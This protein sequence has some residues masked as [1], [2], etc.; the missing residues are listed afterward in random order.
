VC[1]GVCLG[2]RVIVG[3][4]ELF[5]KRPCSCSKVYIFSY[6]KCIRCPKEENP[7]AGIPVCVFPVEIHEVCF[8]PQELE[9]IALGQA[10]KASISLKSSGNP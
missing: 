2:V 10:A 8:S 4:D 7:M 3:G 9:E 5:L 1:L 6:I